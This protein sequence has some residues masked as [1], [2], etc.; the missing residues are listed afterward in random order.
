[1]GLAGKALSFG[2]K[3]LG[4]VGIGLTAMQL[5]SEAYGIAERSGGMRARDMA[6][7]VIRTADRNRIAL[8]LNQEESRSKL[9]EDVA[10]LSSMAD[11]VERSWAINDSFSMRRFAL[12]HAKDLA[13]ISQKST[14]SPVE[15]A[16]MLERMARL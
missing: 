9:L 2:S 4:P 10:G 13:R 11:R 7:E 1:M 12:Q 14:P 5:G 8:F 15:I 3:A 6:D 16:A